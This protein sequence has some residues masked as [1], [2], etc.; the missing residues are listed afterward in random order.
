MAR[1]AP[2]KL[3]LPATLIVPCVLSARPSTAPPKL[4]LP[5]FSVP[6]PPRLPVVRNSAP[7]LRLSVS[8]TSWLLPLR[9]ALSPV[10]GT[11]SG[12]QR[13]AVPQLP[14]PPLSHT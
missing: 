11:P 12:D 3:A 4:A 9:L 5:V 13:L 7:R 10:P 14:A 2:L 6:L 1:A 8:S